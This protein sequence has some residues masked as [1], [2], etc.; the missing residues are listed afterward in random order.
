MSH[1]TIELKALSFHLQVLIFR[2]GSEGLRFNL[3]PLRQ[4]VCPFVII[5]ECLF[6]VHGLEIYAIN[7][8]KLCLFN[9]IVFEI[10][11][12]YTLFK[13]YIELLVCAAL[14]FR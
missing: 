10:S 7:V 9:N 13:H 1:F 4:R 5:L 14:G 6:Y 8:K 12:A 11:S 3:L 2:P